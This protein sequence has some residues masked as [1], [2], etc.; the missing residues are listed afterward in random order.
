MF[1]LCDDNSRD[2]ITR[3]ERDGELIHAGLRV[4]RSGAEGKGK[5]SAS[6]RKPTLGGQKPP[7]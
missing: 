2:E 1:P 4:H 6:L 3:S 5:G 7:Y